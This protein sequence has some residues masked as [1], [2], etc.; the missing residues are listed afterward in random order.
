MVHTRLQPKEPQDI[1]PCRLNSFLYQ[2]PPQ[3]PN[4][5]QVC[6]YI[7]HT[8]INS[9]H[10]SC[11]EAIAKALGKLFTFCP[12]PGGLDKRLNRVKGLKYFVKNLSITPQKTCSDKN[13]QSSM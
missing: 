1:K 13:N 6:I 7:I 8:D 10:I 12:N 9:S 5:Y 3:T 2:E 4:T 11:S